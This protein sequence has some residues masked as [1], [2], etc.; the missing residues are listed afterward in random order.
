MG[1]KPEFFCV[2]MPHINGER[3]GFRNEYVYGHGIHVQRVCVAFLA[4]LGDEL[5]PESREGLS[6]KLLEGG[7]CGE[8]VQGERLCLF[9]QGMIGYFLVFRYD[10]EGGFDV[11]IFNHSGCEKYLFEDGKE[12]EDRIKGVDNGRDGKVAG[13]AEEE[14][15]DDVDGSDKDEEGED[16][17]DDS[18][19]KA[20]EPG[21]L[22]NTKKKI[23]I[24]P[25][26][27]EHRQELRDN[28][29]ALVHL[30]NPYFVVDMEERNVS[31]FSR[32]V[33][34]PRSFSKEH[35]DK[36]SVQATLLDSE[37]R[38]W[39][40]K[41]RYSSRGPSKKFEISLKW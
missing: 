20:S 3:M 13:R 41:V 24:H 16:E 1:A 33:Y 10:D 15:S 12:G 37:E 25:K 9:W 14:S 38:K 23:N 27:G 34:V 28:A 6:S 22:T 39:P 40:V 2:F 21:T 36:F 11:K 29:V 5:I 7:F 19:A 17:F 30:R 18:A 31:A 35:L 8:G 4:T 32:L 26:R